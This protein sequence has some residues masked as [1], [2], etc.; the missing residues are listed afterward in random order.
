M[1]QRQRTLLAKTKETD[2]AAVVQRG[3]DGTTPHSGYEAVLSG[4]MRGCHKAPMGPPPVASIV[5][6]EG[7][8]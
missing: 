8:K 6:F 1:V 5:T 7:F 4:L 2:K 3:E